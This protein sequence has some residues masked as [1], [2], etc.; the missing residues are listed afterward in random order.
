MELSWTHCEEI[1]SESRVK[2]GGPQYGFQNRQLY[3]NNPSTQFRH[4]MLS[5]EMTVEDLG[6]LVA[7]LFALRH[8]LITVPLTQFLRLHL[9]PALKP[10]FGPKLAH[11][12]PKLRGADLVCKQRGGGKIAKRTTNAN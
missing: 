8:I 4:S 12:C 11:R 2:I 6:G 3:I 9:A 5:F 7:A 10:V 1:F